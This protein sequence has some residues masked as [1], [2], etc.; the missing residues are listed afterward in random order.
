MKEDGRFQ[1]LETTLSNIQKRYGEG[2]IMR[3]GQASHLE[4]ES[5]PTGS[6]ALDLALGIGGVPRGRVTEIYGPEGSGKTTVCQ[7]I[8]AEAQ[9]QGG[10]TA[11]IDMEHALDP[12]YA[13]KCGVDVDELYISQPDT[14]EQALEIAEALVRSGAMDAIIVDSVAALVPRAEIEGDMG[15]SHP[16]L[17]ARLM[18]QALRKLSGA[19]KTSNTAMVFTNQLRH[20]IGIMFGSPE[21]TSGGMALKFYASVRLDIRRIQAI[22]AGG[23]VIGNRTRVRVK[24]NKVAP[25]FRECEFD[26]MYDEGISKE[27]DVLDLGVELDLIEKR[28]SFYNY[29]GERLAQGRENAKQALRE[30]PA[31]CFEIENAI[32]RE[33]GL[34][35]LKLTPAFDLGD[36]LEEV[37]IEGTEVEEADLLQEPTE[38]E[39]EVE[40]T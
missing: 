33:T 19:I 10:V 28:G 13:A 14:G 16:G 32:R 17:Q 37:E 8:V 34:K 23:E 31:Q 39:A 29:N 26:I 4:V 12:L 22:K 11:F 36:A 40:I 35:E 25:P 18:S 2:A 30:N 38:E 27:G 15:D 5:I 1:A 9:R 24:K 6:L 20:K 3:L 7:H 21:T